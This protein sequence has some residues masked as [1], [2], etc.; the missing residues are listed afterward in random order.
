MD[1]ISSI[2]SELLHIVI[3]LLDKKSLKSLRL[4]NKLLNDVATQYC[5]ETV[6]FDLVEI[7]PLN[8]LTKIA[9][10]EKLRKCVKHL[11]LRR[12]YGL[13]EN[14]LRVGY[15]PFKGVKIVWGEFDDELSE[16]ED[17]EQVSYREQKRLRQKYNAERKG[18]E[19]QARQITKSLYFRSLDSNGNSDGN[20]CC[21]KVHPSRSHKESQTLHDR[22]LQ[23]FD[24]TISAFSNLREFSHEPA[25]K[26]D[27]CWA[28]R[29]GKFRFDS[30]LAYGNNSDYEDGDVETLQL[31]IVLR[32]LGRANILRRTIQS[33]QLD[34]I[35][36]AFWNAERLRWLWQGSDIL[37]LRRQGYLRPEERFRTVSPDK[38]TE[39]ESDLYNEQLSI[40]KN[41]F[42]HV[43]QLNIAIDVTDEDGDSIET[44]QSRAFELL[45][46]CEPL[47]RLSLNVGPVSTSSDVYEVH[48]LYN[49]PLISRLTLAQPWQIIRELSLELVSNENTIICFFASIAKTLEKLSLTGLRIP[50]G[51][52]TL[53]SLLVR[54]GKTLTN[55]KSLSLSNLRDAVP[56]GRAILRK[57]L[58]VWQLDTDI[59]AHNDEYY[60]EYGRTE[61]YRLENRSCIRGKVRDCERINPCYNHY[62]SAIVDAVLN[63]ADI[64]PELGPIAFL[65]AHQGQCSSPVLKIEKD[66]SSFPNFEAWTL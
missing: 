6:R 4:V 20:G 5:Y 54:I 52:G 11:V 12:R 32:A 44:V 66:P 60:F 40:I 19:R 9:Q 1:I 55:L 61:D 41:A 38:L 31:S 15:F 53:E 17:W 22:L 49:E 46:Y 57:R 39:A 16:T 56:E 45:S 10:D 28:L 3:Q 63:Q 26:H 65:R 8:N 51:G 34:F 24:Q 2:A 23:S 21:E 25:Y 35:G 33:L 7:A 36:P 50:Q 47:E 42:T 58:K 64:L 48:H 27:S 13:R 59:N 29:W 30:S 18:L 14:E 37:T 43:R 62:K